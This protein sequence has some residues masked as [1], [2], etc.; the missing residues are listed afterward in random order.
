MM[1]STKHSDS[2]IEVQNRRGQ[3]NTKPEMIVAYNEGKSPVDLSDQ[4]AAYQTPLRKSIKWYR[5]LAFEILLNTA[6]VNAR[7]M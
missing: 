4:M 5:K 6:M 7:M 2:Q 3:A 1:L